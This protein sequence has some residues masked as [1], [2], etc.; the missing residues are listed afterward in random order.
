[1]LLLPLPPTHTQT[2]TD[3]G[4]GRKNTGRDK[5]RDTERYTQKL[6]HRYIT[7]YT[8]PNYKLYWLQKG[9]LRKFDNSLYIFE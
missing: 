9:L 1:M 2:Y 4:E 3:S 7:T 6:T 8:N 5:D